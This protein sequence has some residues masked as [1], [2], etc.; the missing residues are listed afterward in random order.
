[1][2][3]PPSPPPTS[4]GDRNCAD[5][6]GGGLGESKR[7]VFCRG[8]G[9][10]ERSRGEDPKVITLKPIFSSG[11]DL[12]NFW[13]LLGAAVSAS[14]SSVDKCYLLF[15][16]GMERSKIQK[17]SA[18]DALSR[19]PHTYCRT[20]YTP[21]SKQSSINGVIYSGAEAQRTT[22]S[23]HTFKIIFTHVRS[24]AQAQTIVIVLSRSTFT[25]N[26]QKTSGD[27]ILRIYVCVYESLVLHTTIH[28]LNDVHS[29]ISLRD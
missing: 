4:P 2:S 16:W 20:L 28:Y 18:H 19:D 17:L 25:N 21:H 1:M 8:G 26:R 15:W 22:Y 6:R 23:A 29:A 11:H 14:H 7:S 5:F 9:G 10:G 24:I 13:I 27:I 3:P 12:E